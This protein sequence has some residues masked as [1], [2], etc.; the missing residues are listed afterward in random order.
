MFIHLIPFTQTPEGF[1][2]IKPYTYIKFVLLGEQ[3]SQCQ[4]LIMYIDP[5]YIKHKSIRNANLSYKSSRKTNNTKTSRNIKKYY[6]NFSFSFD[7]E[8]QT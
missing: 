1:V 4:I 6:D 8:F 2:V 3:K 7:D 5:R